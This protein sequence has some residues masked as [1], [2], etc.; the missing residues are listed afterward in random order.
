MCV[1]M[2]APES[3]DRCGPQSLSTLLFCRQ[4][5]LTEFG[6][7]QFSLQTPGSPCLHS[8]VR[9][10]FMWVLK[11]QTQFLMPAQE[12]AFSDPLVLKDFNLNNSQKLVFGL[13]GGGTCP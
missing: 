5:P 6:A 4:K 11:I 10:A 9:G 13:G 7:H 12:Q 2:C 8:P 3:D 1:F